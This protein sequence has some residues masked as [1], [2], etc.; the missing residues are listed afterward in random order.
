LII[1]LRRSL[2]SEALILYLFM[3]TYTAIHLLSWALIRYRLPVDAIAL[4]FAGVALVDIQARLARHRATLR[5]SHTP[6]PLRSRD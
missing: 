3:A 2:S 5:N 6:A 1:S 4:V